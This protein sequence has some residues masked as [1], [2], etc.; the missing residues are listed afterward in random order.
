MIKQVC[1]VVIACAATALFSLPV[2]S[3]ERVILRFSDGEYSLD[4]GQV[5]RFLL[6]GETELPLPEFL[7]QNPLFRFAV[8]QFLRQ[9]IPIANTRV[10][11]ADQTLVNLAGEMLL[12]QIAL[13]IEGDRSKESLRQTLNASLRAG[14]FNPLRFIRSYPEPE[15]IIN[16]DRLRELQ[17]MLSGI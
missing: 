9:E 1:A 15:I 8:M 7:K 10:G 16:G 4:L 6:T 12:D 14:K 17:K 3:A 13:F 11:N 2:H 5:D